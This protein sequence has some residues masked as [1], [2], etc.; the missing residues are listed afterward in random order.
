MTI[1]DPGAVA[2]FAARA[3][4]SFPGFLGIEVTA[5]ESMRVTAQMTVTRLLLNPEGVVHGGALVALADSAC[6]FGTIAHLPGDARSFTTIELKTNFLGS[7]TTGTL[8]CVAT[9]VHLGRTTQVWDAEVTHAES[10]KRL[11]IFRCT[12]LVMR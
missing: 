9:A 11:A 5:V 4:D 8:Q 7:A 10:G 6:G 3:A 12:N 2:A 1:P